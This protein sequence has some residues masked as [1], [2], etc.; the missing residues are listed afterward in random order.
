MLEFKLGC[1]SV[2]QHRRDRNGE[3]EGHD[4]RRRS[5]LSD[6]QTAFWKRTERQVHGVHS[7]CSAH[8][9]MLFS[10]DGFI[11]G[12]YFTGPNDF[13]GI[14]RKSSSFNAMRPIF[15]IN[16]VLSAS[17]NSISGRNN[18]QPPSILCFRFTGY[19]RKLYVAVV[20]HIKVVFHDMH[21]AD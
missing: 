6:G 4:H 10:V 15:P 5:E 21:E 9:G 16:I 12:W 11:F 13:N 14:L 1:Y 18:N 19:F 3:G 17:I 20:A 7:V 8:D 2:E